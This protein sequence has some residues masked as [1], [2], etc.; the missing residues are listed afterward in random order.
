MNLTQLEQYATQL[1]QAEEKGNYLIYSLTIKAGK[2]AN[3]LT[4]I[5]EPHYYLVL[6]EVYSYYRLLGYYEVLEFTVENLTNGFKLDLTGLDASN[7][8]GAF[9]NL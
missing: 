4:Y 1:T 5:K 8:L 7:L 2:W 6:D 9:M 3:D